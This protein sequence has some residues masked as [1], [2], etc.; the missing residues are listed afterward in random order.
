MRIAI[1]NALANCE[2]PIKAM[3]NIQR[4]KREEARKKEKEKIAAFFVEYTNV[5][6]SLNTLHIHLSSISCTLEELA[7]IVDPNHDI[8]F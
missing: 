4:K 6:N 1:I 2:N 8:E 7:N 5:L 3:T